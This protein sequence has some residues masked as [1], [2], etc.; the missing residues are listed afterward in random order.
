MDQEIIDS[1]YCELSKEQ[2]NVNYLL[3]TWFYASKYNTRL[4]PSGMWFMKR[5][6]KVITIPFTHSKP[7][8][9][10]TSHLLC[11]SKNLKTPFY[12]NLAGKYIELFNEE[13]AIELILLDGDLDQYVR[14]Y[15]NS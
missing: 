13:D 11:L 7:H 10:K 1:D 6:F 14:I 3:R 12:I 8:I 5:W 2:Y 9:A 15:K 4:T